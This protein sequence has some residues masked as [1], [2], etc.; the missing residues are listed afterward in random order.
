MILQHCY[1]R[2]E[3]GASPKIAI[4]EPI[5][6]FQVGS[7]R[8]WFQLL[9]LENSSG[10]LTE[11]PSFVHKHSCWLRKCSYFGAQ[12]QSKVCSVTHPAIHSF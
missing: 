11:D 12:Q 8:L 6:L 4:P 2:L 5:L 10:A 7:S 1:W 9:S 3:L